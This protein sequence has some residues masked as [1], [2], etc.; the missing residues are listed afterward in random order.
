MRFFDLHCDTINLCYNNNAPLR[1]NE[2]QVSLDAGRGLSPWCQTFAIWIPDE[3]RGEKAQKR[4]KAALA[5]FERELAENSESVS[6]CKTNAELWGTLAAGRNAALLAVENASALGGDLK[7]LENMRQDGVRLITLTWNGVNEAGCGMLSGET[8][9]LTAFGKDLLR[10]MGRLGMVADVSHI[11]RAGFWDVLNSNTPV[12]ASHS[13]AAAVWMHRRSL[14]D[15]Q[16]EGLIGRQGLMGLCFGRDFLGEGEDAGQEAVLRQIG[17]VLELGGAGILSIG[18][19]FDGARMHPELDGLHMIE[20]LYEY[21][22]RHGIDEQTLNDIFFWNA[23]RFYQR[24]P[25]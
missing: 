20:P 12:V 4:Y 9:G 6:L 25:R 1:E 13:N 2:F 19:D 22:Q 23:Y 5:C 15:D 16:I 3:H 18:S 7:R 24:I 21:L 8:S 11:N 14:E 17:H 10:E